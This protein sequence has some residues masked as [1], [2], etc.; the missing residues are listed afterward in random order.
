MKRIV[1]LMA[2]LAACAALASAPFLIGHWLIV[3]DPL[4]RADAVVVFGGHLPFRAIEAAD[5]YRQGFA[6]AVWIT[7]GPSHDDDIALQQLGIDRAPEH[8]HSREVLLRL[9]VPPD[10]IRIL[11][12]PVRNTAEEVQAIA[13]AARAEKL[14]R[15]ILITSKSHTRRVDI[16]WRR[17]TAGDVAAIVRYSHTDPFDPSHWW[18]ASDD[19]QMVAHELLGIANAW[20]GFPIQP[21]RH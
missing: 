12:E 7:H 15:I 20:A 11:P 3:A 18:K 10:A 4:Q 1:P 13:R 14:H 16:L 19:V 5:I 2:I 8:I 17:L 6:Q 21:S 9:G